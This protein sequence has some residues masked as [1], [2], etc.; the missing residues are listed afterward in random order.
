MSR[1]FSRLGALAL[2]VCGLFLQT[3]CLSPHGET[4][5][6]QQ[7]SA[8]LMHDQVLEE[9]TARWPE[10]QGQIDGAAGYAV[11]DTIVMKILIV[12]VANGYGVVV[13]QATGTKEHIDNFVLALGPGVEASRTHG[14]VILHTKEAVKAASAG[15]WDFGGDAS[16]GL[17]FGDF[18][19]DT[20]AASTGG[21]STV[22]RNMD[23]GLMLHAS[24]FWLK[25][26][27]DDELN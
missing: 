11:Y 18:G 22:Y 9:A 20:S 10:L 2:L 15:E 23:Y 5:A 27:G 8:M 4:V 21:T 12:G 16:I 24:I 25:S 7:G 19:G 26:S 13:D 3:A 17:Q 14:V 1:T 6:E